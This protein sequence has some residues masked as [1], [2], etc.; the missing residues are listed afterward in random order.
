[1]KSGSQPA[2][3]EFD[4]DVRKKEIIEKGNSTVHPHGS[5]QKLFLQQSNHYHFSYEFFYSKK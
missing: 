5:E 1:V 2:A 3:M 4:Y